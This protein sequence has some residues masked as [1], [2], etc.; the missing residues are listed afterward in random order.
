MPKSQLVS[1]C[2]LASIIA[3]ERTDT[4]DHLA[5]RGR[6]RPRP[7]RSRPLR[8][9]RRKRDTSR[10]LAHRHFGS[11]KLMII[12]VGKRERELSAG[13]AVEDKSFVRPRATPSDTN[14]GGRSLVFHVGLLQQR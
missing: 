7:A 4:K 2:A 12:A 3:T 11:T 14:T 6:C 10:P 5:Y 1:A 13:L 9:L 8:S